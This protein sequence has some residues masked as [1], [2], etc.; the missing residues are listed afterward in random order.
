M[1]TKEMIEHLV[2][3]G[4]V[5]F[6]GFKIRETRRYNIF[7]DIADGPMTENSLDINGVLD[8]L[9]REIGKIDAHKIHGD[10]DDADA[11]SDAE[12]AFWDIQKEGNYR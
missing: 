12:S 1:T 10:E 7:R 11:E 5:D 9:R 2:A 3:F 6:R 8:F 4:E